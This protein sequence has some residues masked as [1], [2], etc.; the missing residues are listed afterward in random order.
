MVPVSAFAAVVAMAVPQRIA[1]ESSLEE[2]A[3]DVAGLAVAWRDTQGRDDAPLD[4][5][6]GDCASGTRSSSDQGADVSGDFADRL[7]DLCEALSA[8]VLRDLGQH[9][10]DPGT[11]RGFYSGS[12]TTAADVPAGWSLPCR[13]GNS[14]AV[15]NA[16]HVGV[17]AHWQGPGWAAAQ[18]MPGGVPMGAEGIG[19]VI[20]ASD[21]ATLPPC[22]SV[23]S[24]VPQRLAPIGQENQPGARELAESVPTRIPFAG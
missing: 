17:V 12:Y 14:T 21:D 5:F 11:L 2:T 18:A 15:T 22:G 20:R 23:L 4:A 8:A 19:H 6:F 7:R 24:L 16:V 13:T 9:G 1:A 10:F 3:A